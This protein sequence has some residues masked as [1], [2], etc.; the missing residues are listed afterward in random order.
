M[1]ANKTD[2]CFPLISTRQSVFLI[3]HG[4]GGRDNL[5]NL[6]E[7]ISFS[8]F[9]SFLRGISATKLNSSSGGHAVSPLVQLKIYCCACLISSQNRSVAC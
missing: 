2:V 1:D 6:P 7:G 4:F 5:L 3:V 8:V 9:I